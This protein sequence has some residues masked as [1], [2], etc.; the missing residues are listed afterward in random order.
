MEDLMIDSTLKVTLVD[1]DSELAFSIAVDGSPVSFRKRFHRRVFIQFFSEPGNRPLHVQDVL[2]KDTYQNGEGEFDYSLALRKNNMDVS[3]PYTLFAPFHFGDLIAMRINLENSTTGAIAAFASLSLIGTKAGKLVQNNVMLMEEYLRSGIPE[4]ELIQ[5]IWYWMGINAGRK[6]SLERSIRLLKE[7]AEKGSANAAGKLHE[8]YNDGRLVSKDKNESGKWLQCLEQIKRDSALSIGEKGPVAIPEKIIDDASLE[9]CEQLAEAGYPEA[10][11]L[12]YIF[13]CSPQ[14]QSYN[15]DL[16]FSWLK[17]AA[18]DGVQRAVRVLAEAFQKNYGFIS[19]EHAED[20]LSVLRKAADTKQP[21]AEYLL[22]QIYNDGLCLGQS[23][24]KDKKRAHSM[25][26]A[27]A[28]D[29]SIEAAYDLWEAY[30]HGNQFLTDPKDAWEWLKLAADHGFPAAE[31][32]IGDLY[33]DGKGV[34]KDNEEGFSYMSKAADHNNWDAQL[35]IYQC[36]NHGFYKDVLF[37]KDHDQAFSLLRKY[38]EAGNPK[39]CLLIVDKYE[40]GNQM[41]ME[42]REVIRY[43]ENSAGSGYAPAMYRL[44]NVLLDGFYVRP[45][46]NKAKK[47]LDEAAG[48]GFP[49]AQF[50][51][52]QYYVSGYKSLK[53]VQPNRERAYKWLLKAAQSSPEAQYEIWVLGNSEENAD[54]DIPAQDAMD[55]L[56]R[57]AAQNYSPAIYQVGMAYGK[58]LGVDRNP[59]RGIELIGKAVSLHNPEAMYTLAEMRSKGEF[60]GEAVKQD[61]EEGIHYLLLSAELGYPPACARIQKF[62]SDGSLPE[63]SEL[64]LKDMM[65]KAEFPANNQ[66]AS[67]SVSNG[68]AAAAIQKNK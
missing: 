3:I 52:Y 39:A 55:Y 6:T 59:K 1:S 53:N 36:Y 11:W 58:G 51:L 57:S 62:Y 68:E 50:A 19:K 15:R 48:N 46:T 26:R 65:E 24:Q 2:K 33:I 17:S 31:E 41:L 22:Y 23:I 9:K 37:E 10:K 32:R 49:E 27:A 60:D 14:G 5:K 13:S 45:D 16:A 66:Q 61:S 38:A 12:L 35:K 7:L 25:L 40:H 34:V 47:L 54:L 18:E 28:E 63:E 67:V 21:L 8:L 42:H 20:Y 44:A 4:E 43:L 30:E 56:F 64:W 29:G